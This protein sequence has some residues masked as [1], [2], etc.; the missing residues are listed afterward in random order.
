MWSFWL[1]T[2]ST[3]W[4]ATVDLARHAGP[5]MPCS[6][7]I[8]NKK[9]AGGH[10][11]AHNRRAGPPLFANPAW[12][13]GYKYW[14][15]WFISSDQV[16]AKSSALNYS[17]IVCLAHSITMASSTS[18]SGRQSS[19]A[20]SL[21]NLPCSTSSTFSEHSHPVGIPRRSVAFALTEDIKFVDSSS[22][23]HRGGYVQTRRS[24]PTHGT[25]PHV[26]DSDENYFYCDEV[27]PIDV[28]AIRAR[29][30]AYALM[31]GY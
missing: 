5:V 19:R 27:V 11:R 7:M 13:C 14:Q 31:R 4:R 24:S 28:A 21:T 29:A 6:C 23:Y 1:V 10:Y 22:S 2:I 30:E 17:K 15:N 8:H 26:A 16:T 18:A 9:Q 25:P 3:S 12:G 20:S